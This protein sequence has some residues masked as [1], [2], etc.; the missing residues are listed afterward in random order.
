MDWFR[1]QPLSIPTLAQFILA[2][3]IV[4]Y[5]L[6]IKN[7]S[8]PTR[9]LIFTFAAFGG[10]MFFQFLRD[11][12]FADWQVHLQSMA[13][14]FGV[15]AFLPMMMF[16]YQFLGNPFEKEYRTASWIV[17]IVILALVLDVL[18]HSMGLVPPEAGEALRSA[19]IVF[20][21]LVGMFTVGIFFRKSRLH[22]EGHRRPDSKVREA[23]RH[24][25][26]AFLFIPLMLTPV[27]LR[28]LGYVPAALAAGMSTLFFLLFFFAFI[29][30][31][32][33]HAPEPTTVQVKLVGLTLVTMLVVLSLAGPIANPKIVLE[34]EAQWIVSAEEGLDFEDVYRQRAHSKTIGFFWVVI[35]TSG[36][37]LVVFPVF[38][39]STLLRRLDTL[40]GGVRKINEG[41]LDVE[42]EAPVHDEIGYLTTSF[43]A[44]TSSLREQ[45]EE[46]KG[47]TRKAAEVEYQRKLLEAENAR[48]TKELEEARQL[49]LSMLPREMPDCSGVEIAASMETATEVGGDYYDFVCM[50]GGS[51]TAVIGD[52]TGHGMNAGTVVAATK[53]LYHAMS[54]EEDLTDILKKV[55]FALKKMNLPGL[56]M[57]LAIARIHGDRVELVGSG[58]PAALVYRAADG[59]VEEFPLKGAPL[60]SFLNF[61]YRVSEFVL[62]KGDAIVMLTDGFPELFNPD[63]EMLG[64]ERAAEIVAENGSRSAQEI[65]EAFATEVERWSGPNRPDDDVTVVALK[66]A[67]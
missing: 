10:Y 22:S 45:I 66:A 4:G 47:L 56:Y 14:V 57:A 25:A 12:T 58:L 3:A 38:F 27:L 5:L 15:S 23:H 43:N 7:R 64:Y 34:R 16:A 65:V 9:T 20:V 30:V 42:L 21:A 17:G 35:V 63:R 36:L 41:N 49:Q 18:L 67:G 1:L 11:S 44:M 24:F 33:N 2:A 6:S 31:F 32:V 62:S 48:K 55:S 60:G 39:R 53:G 54:E 52:A 61:P 40:L 51:L 46:I 29:L 26:L 28:E 59:S 19:G 37:V 13:Y 8:K 50:P